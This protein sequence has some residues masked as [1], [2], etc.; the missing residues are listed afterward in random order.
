MAIPFSSAG[1]L[2][3]YFN[4]YEE[5]GKLFVQQID[6]YH[7]VGNALY[8]KIVEMMSLS[9]EDKNVVHIF[10]I[11]GAKEKTASAISIFE[12]EIKANYQKILTVKRNK[13]Y[14]QNLDSVGNTFFRCVK[15]FYCDQPDHFPKMVY[16]DNDSIAVAGICCSHESHENGDLIIDRVVSLWLERERPELCGKQLITRSF[17][18]RDF[19]GRRVI[20][21][22]PSADIGTWRLIFEG[23]RQVCLSEDT[24][25]TKETLHPNDLGM[26]CSSNLQSI[27]VNPIY[28]Y[29]KWLQPNDICEEWHKAF[30]Y[31]CAI[32]DTAW[33]LKSIRKTYEEFLEFLE[34]NICLLTEVCP[35]ISK[36]QYCCTILTQIGNFRK[37][38]RG[39]DEPVISKDMYQTLNSRYV[40]LPYLWSLINPT[41]YHSTFHSNKLNKMIDKA[42]S[43]TDTYRRGVL[44]EDVAAYVL[45]S[46]TGW[47]IT[48]RR[49]RAGTQEID[50]S[51]VNISLDNE[52]WQ[53]GAYIL[54][55]CKNWSTHVDIHHIRN[56]A[57]I[58][59]MKGNKTA[60]LFASNG[61]TTDA[62]EEIKR[63]AAENIGVI[64]VAASDLR[65]LDSADDCKRLILER[66][67]A[68]WNSIE[69]ST[70]I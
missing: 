24:P 3:V 49:V 22:Y 51:I 63:L 64:S 15:E 37:F 33:N 52:R 57:H 7:Y 55:E 10:A 35:I 70:I 4:G 59:S 11:V 65:K 66:W 47:K 58:C 29:G 67:E 34:G 5:N 68:L 1:L 13:T 8:H 19:V 46:V 56:I 54:V 26:F 60:I 45:N 9:A 31:L 69:V 61:I 38:L 20:A 2:Y 42:L 39:E 21:S 6:S 16:R 41:S 48:G 30:L 28:A 53:L 25:Y 14:T 23:G 62:K 32:S 36:E 50:L 12:N 18:M 40:Y 44:W 17:F 43:E 27:L